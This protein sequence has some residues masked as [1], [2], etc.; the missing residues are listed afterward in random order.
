MSTTEIQTWLQES[1][2]AMKSGEAMKARELLLRVL[3]EDDRHEQAWLWLSGVAETAEER[4]ICLENVLTINPDNKVAQTGLTRLGYE[5]PAP[6]PEGGRA[7]GRKRYTVRRERTAVSLASAVLYPEQQVQEW[8][9]EEPE[10]DIRRKGHDTPF[11]AES[12]FEDVWTGEADLCAFCAYELD[13]QDKTCPRCRRNLIQK[14]FRYE[15]P[16]RNI[17]VFFVLLLAQA[18]LFF[19][20]AIYDVVQNSGIILSHVG[21]PMFFTLLFF[22]AAIGINWR[23]VWAYYTAL[24]AALLILFAVLTSILTPLDLTMLQLPVRDPAVDAFLASFGDL[25]S[26]TIRLFQIV[27]ALLSFLFALWIS[28]DFVQDEKRLTAVLSKGHKLAADY[29]AKAKELAKKGMWATAVLHWQH[30]AAKEPHTISYQQQ[31]G[32]A[33]AQLGFYERSLD[34]LQSA[35][36]LSTQPTK[37]RE[38]QKLIQTVTKMQNSSQT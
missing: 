23:Q 27:L 34:I 10:V 30:A 22:T 20:Q 32:L 6:S 17:Y 4:R 21:W 1:V 16:S 15:T 8:S 11:A 28:P 37:Q 12:K 31:L 5:L 19:A 33:Y 7:S 9:W 29:N 36:N 24:G 13:F 2:A 3:Q 18:Q 25:I 38:L 35:L 26:T 14:T